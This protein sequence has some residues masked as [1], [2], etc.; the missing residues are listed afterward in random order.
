M[1]RSDAHGVECGP[2]GRSRLEGQRGIDLVDLTDDRLDGLHRQLN[3]Q[4]GVD[5]HEERQDDFGSLRKPRIFPD[6][7]KPERSEDEKEHEEDKPDIIVP[8][9]SLFRPRRKG[10]G[11]RVER[12]AALTAKSCAG[13]RARTAHHASR[14]LVWVHCCRQSPPLADLQSIRYSPSSHNSGRTDEVAWNP[15]ENARRNMPE[16]RILRWKLMERL[17]PQ[18]TM[19]LQGD[20]HQPWMLSVSLGLFWCILPTAV[21]SAALV[22]QNFEPGNGTQKKYPDSA[23]AQPEYGWGFGGAITALSI[24][25]EPVHSGQRSWKVIIP[26]GQPLQAGTGVPSSTH[27]YDFNIFPACHDRLTFWVWSDPSAAG[28]HTVM[29]KLF[30]RGVYHN[31]GVGLWTDGTARAHEWSQLQVLFSQLPADFD[32]AHLDKSSSS[33]TGMGRIITTIS[34]CAQRR[35]PQMISPV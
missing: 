21:A 3:Q 11:Q 6:E 29:V 15:C 19:S 34:K 27:T 30:D 17:R 23:I 14:H 28:D 13:R 35:F 1:E 18:R 22:Y 32:L 4:D 24:E 7:W 2:V 25:G 20:R 5:D 26:S 8:S 12:L 9:G 31:T 10:D 33:I 16:F